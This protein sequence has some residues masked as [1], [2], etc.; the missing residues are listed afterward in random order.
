MSFCKYRD[1]FGKPNTGIHHIRIFDFAVM[2]IFG[3]IL[4][5]F[6]ISQIYKYNI[7]IIIFILLLIAIVIHRIFCVNTK[8]NMIIFGKF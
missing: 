1:I 6:I 5:A 3:T 4:F 7:F 2:D 8:L